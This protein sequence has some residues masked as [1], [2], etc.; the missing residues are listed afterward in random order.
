MS[1]SK[2]AHRFWSLLTGFTSPSASVKLF[3]RIQWPR[4]DVA[5]H[6]NSVF[7]WVK[8]QSV[9][10]HPF[11]YSVDTGENSIFQRCRVRRATEETN[12]HVIDVTVLQQIM[13]CN[14]WGDI[15]FIQYV[16]K[17]REYRSLWNTENSG[18]WRCCVVGYMYRLYS[19]DHVWLEQE[20]CRFVN[21]EWTLQSLKKNSMVYR[22]EHRC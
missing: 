12:V 17:R 14:H 4:R 15:R 7:L 16:K 9:Y 2:N 10:L 13:S 1:K 19:A 18:T 21:A 6:T 20:K 5:H 3:A 11:C 22:I 8:A